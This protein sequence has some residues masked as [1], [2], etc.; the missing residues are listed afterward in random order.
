MEISGKHQD[1][2]INPGQ[3]NL[4]FSFSQM[5]LFQVRIRLFYIVFRNN[6]INLKKSG[7]LG[8]LS[9]LFTLLLLILSTGTF[10]VI[11]R[12]KKI[13]EIRSDFIN[14]MT[15]EL[16]TPISTISLASQMMAD[17][18]IPDKDKNIDNLAK[19]ISDESMRLKFQVEK[20]LQMA[21][22]EKMKMKL[23]LVEI[24]CS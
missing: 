18:S 22:F 13:S 8:F 17:K 6:N 9:L 15:H 24:G 19:V 1:L 21:I 16:K 20:V 23:N 4:L 7:I 11:F 2:L 3:I 10:I 5:I 12:Q 14:N